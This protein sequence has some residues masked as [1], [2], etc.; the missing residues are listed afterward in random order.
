[1]KLRNFIVN[2]EQRHSLT[3]R[4]RTPR[5]R[6]WLV[7]LRSRLLSPPAAYNDSRSRH[8]LPF[9]HSVHQHNTFSVYVP[10]NTCAHDS[11]GNV[12][13]IRAQLVIYALFAIAVILACWRSPFT[14]DQ[15]G[16]YGVW[17]DI[18]FA[19]PVWYRL[20]R[21]V[22]TAHF[23][24]TPPCAAEHSAYSAVVADNVNHIVVRRRVVVSRH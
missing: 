3:T 20:A 7:F 11:T 14:R 4:S 23:S 5:R 18:R 17:C 9:C 24:L 12:A 22:A 13:L 16:A 8:V 10:V 15:H 19:I 21:P 1:M 6:S 2:L